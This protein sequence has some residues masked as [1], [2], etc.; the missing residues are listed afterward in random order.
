MTS[1]SARQPRPFASDERGSVAIIFGLMFLA[2]T[3][4]AGMAIDYARIT[5]T[6][7]RLTA[8]IDSAALAAGK[9]LLDGRYT[10]EEIEQLALAYF[11]ENIQTSGEGFGD[12]G[13]VT[14]D[15]NRDTGA[16]TMTVDAEVPMTITR[17]AGFEK[18]NLPI[19]AA[20]LFNQ[21]DI[22]L[23]M[24]LDVTGSMSGQ[25]LADLKVAAKDLVDIL[26]PDGG[27]PNKVRIG[28]APYSAAMNAGSYASVVS[29]GA[30]T[31][32]CVWERTGAE[33]YSD[34]APGAGTYFNAGGT[35]KD[36]DATE[37]KSS[38]S[39]PKAKLEPLSDNKTVLKTA[40]DSYKA[41]GYTGGHFGAAWAWYLVS[42][43]WASIWPSASEPADYDDSKTLKAIILM[44]DGIFNTAYYNGTSSYQAVETCDSMKAKDVVVYAVGFQAPSG[45]ESTLKSCASTELHYF[46]ATNGEELRT[47]FV[48]I[49]QQLNNLRLTQ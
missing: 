5:H 12:I 2:L 21:T 37:G 27:T 40:I 46:K 44:T 16:V 9:A 23:S 14:V 49:A 1:A 43:E 15:L 28:L 25:K 13:T 35:P 18:A 39:C 47:A 48:A 34:A 10:D 42:P 26:L 30:S 45:A 8:A 17:I 11:N 36:I 7:S 31:D 22:E 38:Y 6:N 3:F 41:G 32:S 33:A 4:I 19:A 20:T 24:A 29:N